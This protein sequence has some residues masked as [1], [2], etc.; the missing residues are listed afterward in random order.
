MLFQTLLWYSSTSVSCDKSFGAFWPDTRWDRTSTWFRWV[1]RSDCSIRPTRHRSFCSRRSSS[2]SGI[3]AQVGVWSTRDKTNAGPRYRREACSSGDCPT[4]WHGE[5]R[6]RPNISW[7]PS[8]RLSNSLCSVCTTVGRCSRRNTW[9][10]NND[11][12]VTLANSKTSCVK[13]ECSPTDRESCTRLNTSQLKYR[14]RLTRQRL[15]AAAKI[16]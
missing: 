10:N 6:Y 1:S 9:Q 12:T 8:P 2:S 11:K 16:A 4:R 5:T 15:L 7:T 14:T 13:H 3:A